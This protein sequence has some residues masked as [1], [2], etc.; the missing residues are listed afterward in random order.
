MATEFEAA[1]ARAARLLKRAEHFR[2]RAAQATDASTGQ[3]LA[4]L[5]RALE[6]AAAVDMAHAALLRHYAAGQTPA[7]APTADE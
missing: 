2:R 6:A 1:A 5:A 3:R 4:D 7:G